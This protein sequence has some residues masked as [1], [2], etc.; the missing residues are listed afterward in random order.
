ML[1]SDS[2]IWN[3]KGSTCFQS[4]RPTKALNFRRITVHREDKGNN[5]PEKIEAIS[6][7]KKIYNNKPTLHCA[8]SELSSETNNGWI[9]PEICIRD[10]ILGRGNSV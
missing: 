2:S 7:K 4:T 10:C 6:K 5:H 9:H 1:C 3:A 8:K